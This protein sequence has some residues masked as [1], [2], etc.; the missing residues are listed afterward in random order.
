MEVYVSQLEGRVPITQL[1]VVGPYAEGERVLDEAKEAVSEGS[2]H[3][4]INLKDCPF[5]SSAGLRSIHAIYE[6]VEDK[7]EK[8]SVNKG[9]AAGTYKS[10]H[11]KLVHVTKDAKKALT[12][13][14]FDM[15]LDIFENEEEAI[16]SF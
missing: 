16:R 15:F 6:L 5:I 8:E 14:G 4:L 1:R 13:G 12:V 3:F 7:E 11:L 10:P 2:T 9:I